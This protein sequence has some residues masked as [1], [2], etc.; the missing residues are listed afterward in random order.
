M[1]YLVFMYGVFILLG[2]IF[3]HVR[4]ASSI[5]LIMGLLFGLLLMLGALAIYKKQKW[6]SPF[7][8]I[9]I[10]ILD[11]FFTYRFLMTFQ[12]VP[13]GIL[14]LTSLIVLVAVAF[15]MRRTIK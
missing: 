7:S 2:G 1:A 15:Q 3:G 10:L 12:L 13:S 8:L 5:S 4:A 14:A 9:L 6:G 11:I